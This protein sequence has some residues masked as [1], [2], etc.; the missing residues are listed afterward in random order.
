MHLRLNSS[1]PP[2]SI[3][4]SITAGVPNPA[5][6]A[7]VVTPHPVDAIDPW[8]TVEIRRPVDANG[9]AIGYGTAVNQ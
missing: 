3:E 9:V 4:L 5:R 6:S 2:F 8:E 1:R 7:P